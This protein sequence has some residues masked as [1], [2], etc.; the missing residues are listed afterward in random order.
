MKTLSR[1]EGEAMPVRIL[2][3]SRRTASTDFCMRSLMDFSSSMAFPPAFGLFAAVDQGSDFLAAGRLHQVPGHVHVEHQDGNVVLA[4]ERESG[5]IH[6]LE[7]AVDGLG[8]GDGLVAHR[9]LVL[10]GI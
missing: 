7:L 9:V 10:V 3:R 6:H 1:M 2:A 5:G 4:A 8:V